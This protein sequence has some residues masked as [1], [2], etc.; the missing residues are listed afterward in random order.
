[1]ASSSAN[2][3]LKDYAWI[4]WPDLAADRLPSVEVDVRTVPLSVKIPE[5]AQPFYLVLGVTA[6]VLAAYCGV[7][8]VLVAVYLA[9]VQHPV[10]VRIQWDSQTSWAAIVLNIREQLQCTDIVLDTNQIRDTLG[11]G[12]EQA[13]ALFT[14]AD[15][16]D[17][18]SEGDHI[19]FS[20]NPTTSYFTI[21]ASK[22]YLH[23]SIS[24]QIVS[25]VEWLLGCASRQLAS[26]AADLS[27]IPSHLASITIGKP[28]EE[29][30]NVYPH[31]PV[32]RLATDYLKL[33][34]QDAPLSTA[35]Q[36]YPS[37]SSEGE[38]LLLC[39]TI[40]YADLDQK[41]N[42]FARWLLEQGLE[43]EDRVA[44][45]MNRDVLFHVAMMGIMRSG[46][47][48]VPIDPELPEERKSYI[49]RDSNAK[50]V[51]TTE[52]LSPSH[53]FGKA[54][55]YLDTPQFLASIEAQD[56][57]DV[58]FSSPG[59]LSYMLYTSGTTGNPKGCLL[60]QYGL[61][62]A[63]FS[64]SYWASKAKMPDL[65]KGRYLSIASIAFDVHIAEIFVPLVLRM[66][67]LSAPRS[68]L[69]ENLPFYV[70]S[71]NVTHLGLVPSLIEATMNAVQQ[72]G[73]NM[74]LR[75]IASG[76]EKISDA[77]LD[78]WTDHPQTILANFYG[79]S[80]ATIGCCASI[81]SPNTPRANIGRPFVNVS[82]YVVDADM[83]I[84]LRGGVGELV[85]EGPL[86]GRGYHGRPDIAQKVF[87]AWPDEKSWA[88]R[89]GDLVRMMPDSTI[90]ILGRIDT[91]IKIR[92]VRIESE[93]ISAIVRKALPPNPTFTLD[94]VTVL[95]KHPSIGAQQL[96]TFFAWD[97]SVSV[98]VRKSK[99]PQPAAP[100]PG[101]LKSIREVCEAELAS[102]MRPSH[103]VPLSWL[104]L[105]SNGKVDEKA[106]ISLFVGLDIQSL[107]LMG[108]GDLEVE[109]IKPLTA[110]ERAVWEVLQRHILLET[111]HVHAEIN[112]FEFGLDSMGVIK[113]A[114]ALKERFGRRL[115]A[116]DIMKTPTLRGIAVLLEATSASST[117]T[118]ELPPDFFP[119]SATVF[120][121][122][123]REIVESV[124]PP[125]A[126]QEGVLSRS[127]SDD[128]L[129]VQNVIL[130]CL[131]DVSL[132]KL[133]VAWN[134][135]M[136]KHSILR[137]VFHFGKVLSQVVL[138]PEFCSLSWQ[139]KEANEAST[140]GFLQWFHTNEATSIAQ[141]LNRNSHSRP[142]F[143]CTVYHTPFGRVL[144]F[145][146]H[147]A[148]YDGTSLPL[149][150]EAVERAYDGLSPRSTPET[151]DIIGHITS[152]D[153]DKAQSFW[154]SHFDG[155]DWPELVD[156]RHV[157]PP[158]SASC[159][160]PLRTKLS[161]LKSLIA[162]QRVTLQSLFT[163]AFAILLSSTLFEKPDIVFGVIRSGRLLPLDH[164]NT[165]LCP[166]ITVVPLRVCVDAPNLLQ[167]VQNH[168][169]ETVEYEHI[170]LGKVQRWARPGEPLFETI[171]SVS[172]KEDQ[173]SHIWNVIESDPPK[174]DYLLSTEIVISPSQDTV[175]LQAAWLTDIIDTATIMSVFEKFESTVLSIAS[176]D[177]Q[178]P[179]GGSIRTRIQDMSISPVASRTND[180]DMSCFPESSLAEKLRPVIAEF[181]GV[182]QAI[183][184]NSTSFISLG[185]DSIKSVGLAREL[186]RQG[187]IVSPVE[188]MK[189]STLRRL[190][191][192][193]TSARLS[194]APQDNKVDII[195][196]NI[197]GQLRG[198]LDSQALAMG[199]D[200]SVSIYPTTSLQAGMLSQTIGSGGKLYVHAFPLIL[201]PNIDLDRLRSSWHTAVEQI[202]I[203]RTSFH[204]HDDLGIWFQVVHSLNTLDWSDV[205]C[206]SS[207]DM[208]ER[209][210]SFIQES[211]L[212]GEPD[213]RKPPLRVRLFRSAFPDAGR[214]RL[215]FVLHHALYDG[216]SIGKFLD[217]VESIYQGTTFA[218]PV[219]FSELIPQFVFQ[220]NSGTDFWVQKL[221]GY[222]H[223]PLPCFQ[224]VTLACTP[225]I[226]SR[227]VPLDPV[228]L[229][230]V[231]GHANA[232]IQCLAQAAWAKLM[233]SITN[234]SDVVFG[235]IVSGRSLANASDAFG[236]VVNTI[237]C[238][239]QIK[240][241][242]NI[243]LLQAIQRD[244]ADALVWQQASLRSIQRQLRL[245]SLWD[246]IFSFQP[247]E[248]STERNKL[249]EFHRI[250]GVEI[251]TQY[252]LSAEFHQTQNGFH[253]KCAARPEFSQSNSLNN[254][255][256]ELQVILENMLDGPNELAFRNA[257]FNVGVPNTAD[258]LIVTD[259]PLE[260]QASSDELE[261]DELYGRLRKLISSLSKVPIPAIKKK[262]PLASLGIDSI[263]AIQISNKARQAGIWIPTTQIIGCRDFADLVHKARIQLPKSSALAAPQR[264]P[265]LSP[266]ETTGIV[267]RFGPNS[268]LE[269][270]LPMSPGQKF[271]VAAWQGME[272]RKY[273][274]VFMFLLP[275]DVDRAR[276]SV[277]WTLLLQ[278]HPLLRST[279]A[280][281]PNSGEPRLVIFKSEVAPS[282]W[283]EEVIADE[284]FYQSLAVKAQN[285]AESPIPS[286][287]PQARA[288][289][290]YSR[291]R[292]SLLFHLHHFQYDAWSLP[293]LGNELAAIYKSQSVIPSNGLI[294]YL[295]YTTLTR[296]QRVIQDR[297]WDSVIP[298]RFQPNLFPSLLAARH[299]ENGR[300]IHIVKN[301]IEGVLLC[302]K[303][304]AELQRSFYAILMACWAQLQSKYTGV[305]DICFGIWQ[306]G[307]TGS[308]E[309]IDRLAVP[310]VN[311][312]PMFVKGAQEAVPLVAERIQTTLNQQT[313]I[314]EQTDFSRCN[315]L[316][317]IDEPLTNVFLNVFRSTPRGQPGGLLEPVNL[318]FGFPDIT[319]RDSL[320]TLDH[321]PITNLIK[322]DLSIDIIVMPECD[323]IC[324]ALDASTDVLSD[325]QAA[326]IVEEYSKLVKQTLGVA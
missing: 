130:H 198:S 161:S 26:T 16:L 72:D 44:V 124:F 141:L 199:V 105:S 238:R 57:T 255:L 84:L 15:R 249:W 266:S 62:S 253:I 305:D 223:V 315:T 268:S 152:L 277:A 240:G 303:R 154:T 39:D 142:P 118:G 160:V 86:V 63:I 104:P 186:Q 264:L 74:T 65:S 132:P 113:L 324:V 209:L 233:L 35:V 185:L 94:A 183:L 107:S 83:N 248:Q 194:T 112:V 267:T 48:Y 169:S 20:F 210:E 205:K 243:D 285:L 147:H 227:N 318:P 279:F 259:C 59:D 67:I 22:K 102:Y 12:E 181:L 41:A 52:E 182:G 284:T 166:L 316:R 224:G 103:M 271:L 146:I 286:R 319:T 309:N 42:K 99:R 4:T 260:F 197:L 101:C 25:Q 149:I 36:W 235:H 66:P 19:S 280:S 188:V 189:F 178:A 251:Y 293:I 27:A 77:I 18:P 299:S 85:V 11:L 207:T 295:T 13:P 117:P 290:C 237:P 162:Q 137:T 287:L 206:I 175:L 174:A 106:L 213:F 127:T 37:L 326:G 115:H 111:A 119:S 292:S 221:K 17:S 164:V 307:R 56:G 298:A 98:L 214:H 76:G 219:Q 88:Y 3:G 8:D 201:A 165:S 193:L 274:H 10:Y 184:G 258:Q 5:S 301:A 47:C 275:Q 28:V 300:T 93:G 89:T 150:L 135:V 34:A 179:L 23:P 244:N 131:P 220:E 270:I 33:R 61:A 226:A 269:R 208:E 246:N 129:Y 228:K 302:E 168:I 95:A 278:R 247:L 230:A 177:P 91:Q 281:A 144:V 172:V 250:E 323:A 200:D 232:T 1:M 263:T 276:L 145:S 288:I 190:T 21:R 234:T 126:I 242:R 320:P 202:S 311:V 49:A 296:E 64:L 218:K 231:L 14:W 6:R 170:P 171:F 153:Q 217:L 31:A 128:T 222:S 306:N 159:K 211:K 239:V 46:G 73:D 96:V 2:N 225:S 79:P 140:E 252:V 70:R 116:S 212:E 215:V 120:Q 322:D 134:V 133:K 304:A 90:E 196:N 151:T 216:V 313:G 317:G 58:D 187:Y 32:V 45:C 176:G 265:G 321:L 50:F 245:D 261:V 108:S 54:T 204:F 236:P 114:A 325:S 254:L 312:L 294:T 289:L 81:M 51:L 75:Y 272:A 191:T 314:I 257:R 148:I 43:K 69:L 78:K 53:L 273:Q 7:S 256:E 92:G 138:K 109:A 60:T 9:K 29:I 100:P 308:V 282:T 195:Y 310:C 122:Y 241:I 87:K 136:V 82:A 55:S 125:F 180:E 121:A 229:D 155:F 192:A 291:K 30:E 167:I 40:T 38:T 110:T 156:A 123:P 71:L 80:E 297:Y 158:K 203:L 163:A 139:E 173:P 262:T 68:H 97:P 24:Q 157:S 143:D 283:S